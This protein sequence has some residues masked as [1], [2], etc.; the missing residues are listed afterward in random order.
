MPVVEAHV[1]KSLTLSL[2]A[3]FTL[4]APGIDNINAQAEV[5]DSVDASAIETDR[6]W[7]VRARPIGEY[8]PA[9]VA[10]R[11][12]RSDG[13]PRGLV[14]RLVR[15]RLWGAA[16]CY[17][18]A[19]RAMPDAARPTLVGALDVDFMLTTQGRVANA[20]VS[21]LVHDDLQACVTTVMRRLRFP[22]PRACG[23]AMVRLTIDLRLVARRSGVGRIQ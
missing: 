5:R 2:A 11:P 4:V 8:R 19:L 1:D 3:L 7:T 15:E 17:E 10:D 9:L 12:S 18:K 20:R 13:L 22:K 16:Q 21:G 14:R 6:E 23:I